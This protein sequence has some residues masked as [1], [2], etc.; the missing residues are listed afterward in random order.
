MIYI[1]GDCHG[2]FHR[3]STK[4]FPEQHTMS[5]DD[6]IIICGDFGGV[7]CEEGSNEQ[8][9]E[10]YWSDWLNDKNFTTV[11]VDGNHENFERLYNYPEIQW[12]GG[13]VHQ[14][15]ES[16]YHLKRGEVYRINGKSF[17][18]FGGASSHDISDGIIDTDANHDWKNTAKRW[19]KLGKNFRIKNVDWWEQELPTEDEME[20][21]RMSL[22]KCNYKV[23]YVITHCAPSKLIKNNIERKDEPDRLMEYFDELFANITFKK[24]FFGH[25]HEDKEISEKF[26]LLYKDMI[27]IDT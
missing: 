1:T 27:E 8:K 11:F 23:D 2:E 25:Y 16:V 6:I 13:R 5:K 7:W 9:E 4:L 21:G 18:T 15:R 26:R 22:E 12:N 17:F 3:F 20:H 19:K 24:W 10:N 14:V